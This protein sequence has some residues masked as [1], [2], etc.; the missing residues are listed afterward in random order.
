MSIVSINIKNLKSIKDSEI[1]FKNNLSGIYGPNGTGKTAVIEAIDIVRTYYTYNFKKEFSEE[2]K[3][4]ITQNMRVG[5]NFLELDVVIKF[6][7]ILY[8]LGVTFRKDSENSLYVSREDL[9]FKTVGSRKNFKNI[10]RMENDED[11]ILPKL[12]LSTSQKEFSGV[13]D[14]DI[15][16]K[17]KLNMKNLFLEFNNFYSYLSLI[18][19][20]SKYEKTQIVTEEL[21]FF[22]KKFENIELLLKKMVVVNLKEQALYNLDIL[23]PLNVHSENIHGVLMVNYKKGGTVY[24]EKQAEELEKIVSQINSIFSI[25]VPKAKLKI[26]KEIETLEKNEK[27]IGV[28]IFVERNNN[29]IPLEMESTGII[30]LVSLLSVMIYYV[31]DKDAIVAIDELDIHIFEYLLATLLK[32]LSTH[33]KGQLIFTA[34]NLLPLE[35][36]NRNAIIISTKN[37]IGDVTYTYLKGTSNTTNLRQKYLKSQSMWSEDNITPLLLNSSALE[38]YIKKL[39]I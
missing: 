13:I 26:E 14:S 29:E 7:E 16:S 37:E 1:I 3:N 36:L 8:K 33:A 12:Y 20:Y 27:K 15:L 6:E 21:D 5:E 18:L 4:K 10:A 25:I 31:Q 22:I 23:I 11:T 28:K 9:A 34:H 24:S 19:K 2:L 17:N 39:V 35:S 30:K 32:K 38:L